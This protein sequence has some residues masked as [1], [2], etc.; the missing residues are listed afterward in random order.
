MDLKHLEKISKAL[1]D[2][3]R[4]KIISDISHRG[5]S[6][7]C[8]EIIKILELAQHSVSHQINTLI[9]AVIIEP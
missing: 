1:G 5:G 2:V 6:L 7:Q 9:D 3:N 4:L 8:S